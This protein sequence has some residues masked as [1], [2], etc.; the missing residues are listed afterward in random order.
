MDGF[1]LQALL[2]NGSYIWPKKYLAI[3]DR[4]N[5]AIL[6]YDVATS[7]LLQAL[8]APQNDYE[9]IKGNES[10]SLFICKGSCHQYSIIEALL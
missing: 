6:F 2:H 9:I 1:I 7:C 10:Q 3:V 8:Q 5:C 4:R